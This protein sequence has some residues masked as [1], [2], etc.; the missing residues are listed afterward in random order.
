MLNFIS[1]Q[2]YTAAVLLFT[3]AWYTYVGLRYYQPEL[4]AFFKIKPAATNQLPPVART[5]FQSVM[6]GIQ[7]DTGTEQLNGDEL[8][9]GPGEPDSISDTTLPRGP[10]DDL[11]AEAEILVNAFAQAGRKQDFISLL[12]VLTG[13]YE[14]YRD[15]ISLEQLSQSLRALAAGKI[16]FELTESEWQLNWPAGNYA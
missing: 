14:I 1:W 6:G 12:H 7:P 10:A 5:P 2:Q 9:F 16:P 4:A 11:F 15:E 8:I 13:K 3:T